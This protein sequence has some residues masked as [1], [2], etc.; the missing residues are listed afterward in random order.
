MEQRLASPDASLDAPAH[1]SDDR[2]R[3]ERFGSD[4]P[5]ADATLEADEVSRLVRRQV[6]AF[7][8]GL[9][10]RDRLIF[11]RRLLSETPVT[12]AL[13]AGDVGVTR[14]RIR[15]LEKRLKSRLRAH[16]EATLGE[17]MEQAA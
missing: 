1:E 11:R 3:L 7:G 9:R 4:G 10:G 17:V 12:L 13:L 5:G 8:H 15:Q 2:D 16:L 14:E 6:R